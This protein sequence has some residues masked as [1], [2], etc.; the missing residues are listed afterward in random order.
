MLSASMSDFSSRM[1]DASHECLPPAQTYTE[2]YSYISLHKICLKIKP[3]LAD[4]NFNVVF[5]KILVSR[6]VSG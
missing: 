3:D 1:L 5:F 6:E 2:T 4:P